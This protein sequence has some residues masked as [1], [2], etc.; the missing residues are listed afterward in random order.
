MEGNSTTTH[1]G[2]LRFGIHTP[3][4]HVTIDRL[5]L[6]WAT[7]DESGFDWISVW[8]HFVPVTPQTSPTIGDM[9]T[10][11]GDNHEAVAMHAT[12][13]LT[14]RRARVGCLVYNVSYRPP[15]VIAKAA[16]TI[17]HLSGGRA[18]VGL[19][20]GYL[21]HEY[22]KFGF[23]FPSAVDR[24]TLLAASTRQIRRLLD[25]IVRPAP[26]QERLPIIIGGGG[27]QRTIPTTA[28]IADGWNLAMPTLDDFA[29]KNAALTRHAEMIDR[30]PAIIERTVS[31]GLCFEESDLPQRFG[32]RW[33]TLRPAVLVGSTQ[34]VVDKVAAYHAAGADTIILS[35][36]YP[37]DTAEVE[38]FALD[39]MG[40]MA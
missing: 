21:E 11:D 32:A 31:L 10:R 15:A 5:K 38:R 27:E 22:A 35:L 12:L 3:L 16:A 26:I 2:T 20:A 29:R 6:L 17:D 39:V 33:E 36:R 34:Q 25:D 40:A 8:D 18:V 19:G 7:A 24:S 30:D 9:T 1:H 14:T 4:Q 28:A 13:A 23:D 37:Y